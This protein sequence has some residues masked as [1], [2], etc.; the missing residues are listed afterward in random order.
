MLVVIPNSRTA[1]IHTGAMTLRVLSGILS[2]SAISGRA[3]ASFYF[4]LVNLTKECNIS[5]VKCQM[6]FI[7][8]NFMQFLF[9]KS[10]SK[11][12]MFR[13]KNAI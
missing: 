9:K 10:F 3:S 2:F 11:L 8:H 6:L 4:A 5:L 1:A 12:C 7:R 13:R